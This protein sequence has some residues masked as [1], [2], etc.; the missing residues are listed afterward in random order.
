MNPI[1]KLVS[2]LRSVKS[3]A[4]KVSWPSRQDTIRYSSLVIGISLVMAAAFAALDFGFT[5]L[6]NAT[7]L[8]IAQNSNQP[9]Q[10]PTPVTPQTTATTTPTL[11]LKSLDASGTPQIQ[12]IPVNP[13]GT[14][15][16]DVTK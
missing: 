1:E 13:D 9:A 15:N 10:P 8:P 11:D 5:A 4:L 7:L 2:Y 14:A 3:E 16:V 6:F 12:T